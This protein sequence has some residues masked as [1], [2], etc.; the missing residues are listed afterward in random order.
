MS[1]MP[2]KHKSGCTDQDH[3]ELTNIIAELGLGNGRHGCWGGGG[4]PSQGQGGA[5]GWR[6][7]HQRVAGAQHE[8]G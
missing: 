1:H 7:G 6:P 2:C 4:D 8:R 3:E 5:G